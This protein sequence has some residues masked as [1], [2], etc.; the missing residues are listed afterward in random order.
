MHS[1]EQQYE[2]RDTQARRDCLARIA[3]A[4]RMVWSIIAIII[5]GA[6][7]A[8]AADAALEYKVKAGFI[9]NFIKFVEWPVTA[10]SASNSSV[11]VGV[12]ADDLAASVLQQALAGKSVNGH[13]LEVRLLKE[14]HEAGDCH[15][16]F[17]GR[18]Q[19]GRV[20]DILEQLKAAPVLTVSE[21]DQFGQRG[22]MINLV[23]ND[24]SFRFEINLK[25]LERAGL[26]ISSRL[27]SQATIVK[28]AK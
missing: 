9:Y 21:I 28:D 18:A 25:A 10:L 24:D 13:A 1:L 14:T 6:F 22:G 27:S 8:S 5:G 19:E 3:R 17:I 11:V 4:R 26:K 12:L 16:V 23:R 20:K 7:S 15:L 2:D